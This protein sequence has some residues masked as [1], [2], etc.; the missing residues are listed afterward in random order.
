MYEQLKTPRALTFVT[1][2]AL[3]VVGACSRPMDADAKTFYDRN[4]TRFGQP[5][6]RQLEQLPFA[7]LADA[8]AAA[9]TIKSGK[10]LDD[11]ATEKSI[12][13]VDLGNVTKAD[14]I[15]PTVA[16]AAFALK[17]GETSAA[18]NSRF[19]PVLLRVK[20]V[21][22]G[23]VKPFEEVAA[24]IKAELARLKARDAIQDLHDKIE[25]QRA[26]ARPL[27]DITRDLTLTLETIPA[28]DRQG[29][30]ATGQIVPLPDRE[31][32][33]KAIFA[34]DV[35]VDNEAVS[36]RDGGYV[37]FDVTSI[38]PARDRTLDEIRPALVE[39]W[40][41]DQTADR[42]AKKAAEL[43]KAINGG[44]SVADA[45]KEA[46]VEA[47]NAIGLTRGMTD[48]PVSKPDIPS[49]S[50]GNTSRLTASN[51]GRPPPDR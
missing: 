41:I 35:G 43:S 8:E 9:A 12:K 4:I 2:L 11:V 17:E 15:D 39:A 28:L 30:D 45:A 26:S 50:L 6:R 37:W 49:A 32:L 40:I 18:V 14:L 24:S 7:S 16:E 42:L 20:A 36:T 1:A 44:K 38:T 3:S 22:A 27:A 33:L 25:D 23:V 34:S 48:T 21:T 5:E 13:P 47:K 51:I 31:A 46:G 10:S 29:R 19:G